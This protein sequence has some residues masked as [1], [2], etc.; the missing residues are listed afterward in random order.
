MR[1]LRTPAAVV[2]L[3]FALA[4]LAGCDIAT[5]HFGAQ[6][7]SEWRRTYP[8][9]AGG[10]VEISNVNGRIDVQPSDGS[11][12][13]VLA[14][15]TGR[16]GSDE[17][18]KQALE[19]IEIVESASPSLVRIETRL[20]QSSGMFNRGG[21]EVKYTVRVPASADV[22]FTT[23]NGGID[24]AGLSGTTR[25][26]TTNGGI[27]ARDIGGAIEASTTNGGVEVDVTRVVEPGVKLGCTNGGITL[28][29]PADARATISA[30]VANGGIDTSGLPLESSESSR[31]RLEARLH[32]GGPAITI[33]GTN[34]G[35]RIGSR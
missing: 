5:A 14:V 16:G 2:C 30:S 21:Y 28:R 33:E 1:K 18:A 12:V 19:R 31:R 24:V 29:L 27:H 34:G 3:P 11:T 26:E 17:A 25:L 20:P 13:D 8:L 35:I 7:S 10:Q 6:Q 22:R 15:K 32:G 4:A 9:Q 23:V